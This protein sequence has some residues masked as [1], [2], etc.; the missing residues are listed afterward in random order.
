MKDFNL[1]V[2]DIA[3]GRT[4]PEWLEELRRLGRT[5]A[6]VS[7]ALW[8]YDNRVYPLAQC[9]SVALVHC[10]R[11]LAEYDAIATRQF[12]VNPGAPIELHCSN[13]RECPL[14]H[15]K[16]VEPSSAEEKQ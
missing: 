15:M 13:P 8:A 1:S 12:M 7:A 10:S 11:R 6:A 2:S 16:S 4:E 9:L 14:R 5:D 3:K